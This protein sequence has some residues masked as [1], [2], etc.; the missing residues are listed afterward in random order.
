MRLGKVRLEVLAL[1]GVAEQ[2]LSSSL[3]DAKPML[4]GKPV[5]GSA[6]AGDEVVKGTMLFALA[7]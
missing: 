5:G 1:P 3:A 4:D 6:W 2:T 7:Q